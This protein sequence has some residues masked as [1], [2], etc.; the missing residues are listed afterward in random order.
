[1]RVGKLS[2]GKGGVGGRWEVLHIT[3]G[4][5]DPGFWFNAKP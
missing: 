5:D 3:D 2:G 1:M 4:L